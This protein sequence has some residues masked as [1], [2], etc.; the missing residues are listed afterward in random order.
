M[1]YEFDVIVIGAGSG[2]L[3]SDKAGD[4]L[5]VAT[6]E[7]AKKMKHYINRPTNWQTRGREYEYSAEGKHG[8]QR[9]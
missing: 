8:A 1:K 4:I 6:L 5:P 7:I 3:V 2:G 9:V